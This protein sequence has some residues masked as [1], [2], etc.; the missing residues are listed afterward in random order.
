[1][2]NIFIETMM[3]FSKN[4]FFE[5]F[6]RK[7]TEERRKRIMIFAVGTYTSLGGPGVALVEAMGEQLKFLCSSDQ[8]ADPTWVM[9]SPENPHILYAAGAVKGS[10]D[11]LVASFLW[12]KETLTLLS[13]QETGGQACCHLCVD[14]DESHLYAANYLDGSVSVF[15]LENGKI[16]PCCQFIRHEAPLGPNEK[17]QEFSHAHQ[18][19]FRPGTKEAFV[20]NLGTDQ[21]VVYERMEN[22]LLKN[23]YEIPAVQP[24]TGPRHLIFD[25]TDRFYLVGELEGWI[26]TYSFKNNA[27]QCDQL[28]STLPEG[29]D[30]PVNT[31]AA[32]RMDESHVY[33]SNRGQ[34]SIVIFDKQADHTLKLNRHVAVPGCFP[35][36]FRL[37]E[38]GFLLA[39]QKAGGVAY[40]TADGAPVASLPIDG[41]VCLCPLSE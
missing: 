8:V 6:F 9:Q 24:G 22:G 29:Y 12:E 28:L 31:A 20:C 35:R 1:M 5:V 2:K 25:G 37:W 17:R 33:V 15:P 27:W 13:T 26:S 10:K 38:K 7:E 3:I 23:T 40:M 16:L 36:D 32:I 14:E 34:D 19:T 30:G 11:G 41:A 4:N 18:F 39:Q 21:V